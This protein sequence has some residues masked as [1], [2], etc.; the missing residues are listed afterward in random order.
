MSHKYRV[1]TVTR[2][3]GGGYNNT[4]HYYADSIKQIVDGLEHFG[5][6]EKHSAHLYIEYLS[7]GIRDHFITRLY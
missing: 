7:F 1:D 6:Y 5:N 2:Y 4:A 3:H